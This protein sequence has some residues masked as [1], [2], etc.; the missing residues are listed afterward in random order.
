MN[1]A[2][3]T[4]LAPSYAWSIAQVTLVAAAAL[5]VYALVR[6]ESSHHNVL[7]LTASLAIAAV[8]TLS[9]VSPWPSWNLADQSARWLAAEPADFRVSHYE[10][11]TTAASPLNPTDPVATKVSTT[12]ETVPVLVP[13]DH[14]RSNTTTP[15]TPSPR[16]PTIAVAGFALL[17]GIGIARFIVGLWA[18]ERHRRSSVPIDDA[19]LEREFNLLVRQFK[20][21]RPVALRVA[22]SLIIPAT[23]GWRKPLV[24]VPESFSDWSADERRVVLAHELA[25]VAERH[26]PLWLIGQFAVAANFYH[27]LVH[28]LCRRLRLEQELAADALAIEVFTDRRAYANIL[29]GLAL[30]PSRSHTAT[31]SLGLYMSR[32]LVMRRIAM[33]RQT[34]PA[35][36]RSRLT[37]SLAAL[38]LLAAATCAV[39][40]RATAPAAASD[41]TT[42]TMHDQP[43]ADKPF[44]TIPDSAPQTI[45]DTEV[46]TPPG[47]QIQSVVALLQVS[48]NPAKIMADNTDR[49]S[50]NE[51]KIYCETQIAYLYSYV[52]AQAAL[53]DPTVKD[54][55]LIVTQK[56]PTTWLINN[57]RV[58]FIPSSE[59]LSIEMRGKPSEVNQLRL[60]VDAV[61]NAYLNEVVFASDQ[62]RNIVRDA[63]RNSYAKLSEEIHGKMEEQQALAEELGAADLDGKS[64]ILQDLDVK[65]L[66]RVE[67]ELLR[68]EDEQLSAQ[69][70]A[71][72]LGANVQPKESA[73]LKFYNKRI[74]DLT[75]R[76]KELEER[77]LQRNQSSVELATLSQELEQ[78]QAVANEMNF[79]LESLDIEAVAP[80][81]IRLIQKAM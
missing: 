38:V 78:L 25:H 75:K 12:T 36:R 79:K 31:A 37:S 21:T 8:L 40:L 6:R 43:T 46:T 76:Q 55:P 34:A 29:A 7:L 81:R 26:Y 77:I 67:T 10:Q 27:P 18:V 9:F 15:V 1:S 33:L 59:I 44:Q 68:L 2:A 60:L 70:Y 47:S 11:R 51:W 71:D 72:E 61:A 14:E 5:V 80:A 35:P 74:A 73:K 30:A 57:L 22:P 48:R 16:L 53:R 52:V 24:L 3:L 13:I 19:E 41:E 65:R 45:L 49:L 23:I 58:G 69:T 17:A 20:I 64:R 54:L 32:P 62:E 42:F 28:W 50:D 66:D 4:S 39:G 63:L 56:D